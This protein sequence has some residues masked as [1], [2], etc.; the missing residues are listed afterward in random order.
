MGM[1]EI[2]IDFKTLA[3]SAV[4]RSERGVVALIL[5]DSTDTTF[6]TK[7]YTSISDVA[8]GDWTADNKDYIDKAF[9]GTPSKIIVERIN[10]DALDYNAALSR[11]AN[12]QFNYLAVPGIAD[13]DVP[14]IGS[15]IKDRRD[16]GKKTFKAVLPNHAADHEGVI[17]FATADIQS[18]S[19][20]Y[21]TAEYCARIAGVL[22][23]LPFTR[24]STYYALTEV[25]SVTESADPDADIDAGKLILV[26]DGAKIKIGRG[27]N[28]LI[29]ATA[30]K[31]EIFKKI[32]IVEGVDLVRDDIR[33]TFE[34]NYVGKVIN[35]YDSKVLFTASVNAYLKQLA[36][37]DILDRN[38]DN[39]AEVDVESQRLYLQGKGVNVDEM[40]EQGIKEYNTDSKVFLKSNVKFV[41]AIEDLQFSVYM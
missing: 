24:S 28:S 29:T 38:Y 13:A 12:K 32:K 27:V 14:V 7:I 37:S 4:Q 34:N 9:M 11:L 8:A 5:K 20:T 36:N 18:G 1:P 15:W 10:A 31:G 19:K 16:N 22:A 25:E 21:T 17:N 40:D 39:R 23:G 6:D 3:V 30:A 26:N 33:N 41:D 35:H 2:I